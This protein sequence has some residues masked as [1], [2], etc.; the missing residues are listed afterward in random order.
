MEGAEPSIKRQRIY[1]QCT[2]QGCANVAR[3]R[4][5]CRKHGGIGKK[6]SEE[7]CETAAAKNGKC[8]KHGG[9]PKCAVHECTKYPIQNSNRCSTHILKCAISV[10]QNFAVGAT[11]FC[12]EHGGGKRCLEQGCKEL[13]ISK[14]TKC[15]NHCKVVQKCSVL[16]CETRVAHGGKC[17]KHGGGVRCTEIGCEKHALGSSKKCKV[18]G[19]GRRCVVDGCTTSARNKSEKCKFHGGGQRCTMEGCV[20]GAADGP[21]Q[22]CYKHGGGPRCTVEGCRFVAARPTNKCITHGGGKR[23]PNCIDWIDSRGA[24][25][26]YDNYCCTCF[27]RLFP[28]DPRSRKKREPNKEIR[29]RNAINERFDGFVH[30]LPLYVNG[31]DCEHKRRVDH[32]KLINGTMLAVETDEFAHRG[33]D[34]RDEEIRYDD[35]YMLHSGKWIFIRFNPDDNRDK[36]DFE[37]KIEKLLQTMEE[38]I[39]RIEQGL[40]TEPVEIIKLFY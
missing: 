16:E 38:S 18:H 1:K 2:E 39:Q 36:T 37:D 26:L 12:V 32:R 22:R 4:G 10:C 24:N 21:L 19:G 7:G 15:V 34:E 6:C 23:C 3:I 30:N 40:N 11:E 35:L 20:T 8:R 5:R 33:Y 13:A 14:G 17:C 9:R 29:V 28:D 31:C 27:K 25:Y